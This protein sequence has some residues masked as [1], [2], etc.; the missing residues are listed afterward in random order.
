MECQPSNV[1]Q[2]VSLGPLIAIILSQKFGD[3]NHHMVHMLIKPL[4]Q[5]FTQKENYSMQIQ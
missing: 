3:E 1:E 5:K 4:Y 2:M